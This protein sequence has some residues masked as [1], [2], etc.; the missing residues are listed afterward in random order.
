MPRF[1]RETANLIDDGP[2]VHL[3]VRLV[4]SISRVH[5]RTFMSLSLYIYIHYVHN[6]R[7]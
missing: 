5:A 3:T 2:P 1:S 7:I 4:R 6:T